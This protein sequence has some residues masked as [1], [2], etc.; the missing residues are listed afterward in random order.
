MII[1]VKTASGS[2][3]ELVVPANEIDP[4]HRHPRFYFPDGNVIF[5][6]EGWLYNVHRYY[7][8]RD[9][10]IFEAMFSLPCPDG[11][12]PEGQTDEDPIILEGIE[13]KDF[14][15]LLSILYPKNFRTCEIE[16]KEE[17]ISVLSLATRWD[18]T[19]IRELALSRLHPNSFTASAQLNLSPADRI[20]LGLR[21]DVSEWL[22]PAYSELCMRT[23]AL[24]LEEGEILGMQNV[25]NIAQARQAIRYPSNLNRSFDGVQN[26]VR[27]MCITRAY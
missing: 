5:F 23:E 14:D 12:T 8:Q 17:W 24:T 15:R 13:A 6:V 4:S 1:Y 19:S 22:L 25:I 2:T 11:H 27:E 3:I 21:F 26:L 16:T 9:S 20:V 18:F 10:T 7:F